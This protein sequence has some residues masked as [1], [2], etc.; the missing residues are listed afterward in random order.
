MGI[1]KDVLNEIKLKT[2]IYDLKNNF[3]RG[4]YNND[5]IDRYGRKN[6][7]LRYLFASG[8]V[9]CLKNGFNDDR[10]NMDF[11]KYVID[12][13]KTNINPL[14]GY[15]INGKGDEINLYSYPKI[16]NIIAL[17]N[18]NGENSTFWKNGKQYYTMDPVFLKFFDEEK[19]KKY[20][21][22]E[23]DDIKWENNR[24][25]RARYDT[26]EKDDDI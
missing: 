20:S 18:S 25:I 4:N 22:K 17:K 8:I 1:L 11:F 5:T 23:L 12:N 2:G 15:Y 7:D 3:I 21:K 16:V 24:N 9:N 26:S 6:A 19:E 14:S 10:I 13:N